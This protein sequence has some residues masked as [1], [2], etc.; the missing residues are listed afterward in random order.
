MTQ[1]FKAIYFP[2]STAGKTMTLALKDQDEILFAKIAGR[3]SYELRTLL[4][5][6]SHKQLIQA[7]RES[8]L[9]LNTF[10]LRL[11]RNRLG[12]DSVALS[13]L[14]IPGFRPVVDLNLDPIQATFRGGAAE[15][16]HTWYPLPEGYSPRFV[17]TVLKAFAPTAHAVFDPF[18]GTGTTAITAMQCRL[19]AYYAEVNP[20]LQ[21]LI[22]IKIMVYR[23]GY[24]ERKKLASEIH[25]LA[26]Q[27]NELLRQEKPDFRLQM[28][29]PSVFGDSIFFDEDTFDQVLRSRALLDRLA[30]RRPSLA[31]LAIVAVL[32]GLIPC[33]L[34]IRSGDLRY[35]SE[36]ELLRRTSFNTEVA[37]KLR[38]MSQDILQIEPPENGVPVFLCEDA[39]NLNRL[40]SL[41]IDAVVTSPPYLNGTNY[42]RNSK[43]ELWFV[44]CLHTQADLAAF[45]Y[46]AVTSGINDVTVGKTN[47]ATHPLVA[48]VVDE[49]QRHA[50]DNRIPQ[51]ASG[52]FS[53]MHLIFDGLRKHLV[54]GATIAIDIGDSAYAGVH[55]PTDRLLTA[56]LDDLGYEFCQEVNLRKRLSRDQTELRQVLLAFKY[57]GEH[58]HT[59]FR[60]NT[61]LWRRKWNSFKRDLPHRS[62][63]YSKRNWG[64]PLH[65]LCSY[66]GKMKPSLAHF[67]VRTFVGSHGRMLDPF[68]GVGTIPFE[69]SLQ[70]VEAFGFEIS[71]AALQISCAKLE[72]SRAEECDELVTTLSEHINANEPSQDDYASAESI[73]FNGRIPEYF[74]PKTLREI[75][76]ARQYFMSNPPDSPSD[77]MVFACLLHILHGNRPYALSRR[78][79]P[80]TPF[81]P[82]GPLEYRAVMPRLQKKLQRSLEVP[83]PDG[84]VAGKMYQ[85][86]AT[87]WWPQE[88][89]DLDAIITSPPFFDSTRFHMGNWM[90]LWFCGWERQDFEEKPL[91]FVDERQKRSMHVYESIFRQARER[92]RPSGVLV[93]HLGQSAKCDMAAELSTIANRWFRVADVF[94]EDVTELERHGISDKGSVTA[95]QFLVLC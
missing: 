80:I 34:L 82:T 18:S 25:D 32:A 56:I 92:L 40:P 29:F 70:G 89:K 20:V 71:P 59:T 43:I 22:E 28:S 12:D 90:R 77:A 9:P 8:D 2:D 42:F 10:C 95:H 23:L 41:S 37:S 49:L 19:R 83:R 38:V 24:D 94:S 55:V 47:G 27:W 46:K 78:S 30:I 93:L 84:F 66:H 65:S 13:Q 58:D 51:M 36:K 68:A 3:S 67:L 69:A 31:R 50:Y 39:R 17:Q 60:G 73:A 87:S 76:L 54:R 26:D 79:H 57:R 63:G 44:R 52:Y 48:D 33:S 85:Q 86:D 11:L 88:V 1:K 14:S 16:L 21:F 35:R 72:Q 4:G 15:P 6:Q 75:L 7:A 61:A 74:H 5:Y 91:A 45:R 62:T 64:H 53:D 81:K